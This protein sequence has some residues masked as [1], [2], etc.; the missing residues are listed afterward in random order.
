MA[1]PLYIR[2]V[3]LFL[4]ASPAEAESALESH[5]DTL[6]RTVGRRMSALGL[7]IDAVM[8][9]EALTEN[10][11]LVFASEYGMSRTLEDYL[12]S[13]PAPSPLS[14]Q[15]SIHPAGVE[16]HLV[17]GKRRLREFLPIAGEARLLLPAAL[18]AISLAQADT[19][20]LL[21][22]EERGTRMTEAGC[23]S[24]STFALRLTLSADETGA[25]GSITSG[26]HGGYITPI[27]F[28]EAVRDR[29]PLDF[30]TPDTGYRSLR[31]R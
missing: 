9:G 6:P 2:S 23:A 3:G 12:D 4:P 26:E 17:P 1:R 24:D 16:Q 19:A 30:G 28:A 13:F 22:G 20:R 8:A 21:L 10:D 7:A 27:G 5:R 14:F 15:N 18:R 31:W 29:A 11:P 25:I